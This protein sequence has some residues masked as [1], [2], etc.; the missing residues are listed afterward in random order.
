MKRVLQLL[1]IS[2]MILSVLLGNYRQK[3]EANKISLEKIS[4]VNTSVNKTSELNYIIEEDFD[5]GA[6][7]GTLPTDWSFE[8]TN[9]NCKD[10][11]WQVYWSVDYL[12]GFLLYYPY[13]NGGWQS[14]V[15]EGKTITCPI[16]FTGVETAAISFY[17]ELNYYSGSGIT[18][19]VKYRIGDSEWNS[20]WTETTTQTINNIQL[21]KVPEAC[22]NQ[23][24]VQ[25]ALVFKG[26]IA[27]IN[28]WIID[29]FQVFIP[30]TDEVF[31][32]DNNLNV[33]VQLNENF[34]PEIEI[35]SFGSS[36]NNFNMYC[37]IFHG[38][39]EIYNHSAIIE[40]LDF[41]SY[42][43]VIFPEFVVSESNNAYKFIFHSEYEIDAGSHDSNTG[44]KQAVVWE[45]FTNTGCGPCASL[46]PGLST[47]IKSMNQN[48][49]LPIYV[50]VSWPS[51]ADP[52]YTVLRDVCDARTQYY[53]ITGVPHGVVDGE[54]HPNIFSNIISNTTNAVS[55]SSN[56]GT[57]AL[58]TATTS[59]NN[60]GFSTVINVNMIGDV[61]NP[62]D[63]VLHV[64]AVENDLKFNAPNGERTF[65]WVLR[66]Y[67]PDVSG[68]TI[69]LIKGESDFYTI[70]GDFGGSW[71]R[72]EIDLYAFIQNNNTKR[73][74][75]G[76]RLVNSTS[77][78]NTDIN[79]IEKFSLE[80][81]Y[82][83]PFNPTT[84]ISYSIPKQDIV[85]INIYDIKGN[86]IR[87]L[88]NSTK[89]SGKYSVTWDAKSD[90][91]KLVPAGLYFYQLKSS[92]NIQTKKMLL[93]K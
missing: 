52:Y 21:I 84:Q 41:L 29:D 58:M 68:T 23:N 43:T 53:E 73:I 62:G 60:D 54:I 65:D 51:D 78:E 18:I 71:N 87:T 34:V 33:Q 42:Q 64:V 59:V 86:I 93:V 85:E 44:E 9:A 38:E 79:V 12:N 50:H 25:F 92:D 55:T 67:Y 76:M 75:Q 5:A 45:E 47:T 15:D 6:P 77:I 31:I 1:L 63:V 8:N 16:D 46:N 27:E 36:T 61:R 22:L 14:G 2:M 49:I 37:K 32:T 40:T 91:G 69:N 19:S 81:N 28:Y 11:I 13:F 80:Q 30:P 74:I 57:P 17:Q 26:Q 66:N 7:T 56:V 83:N 70:E 35:R 4:T 39:T 20:I 48:E 90:F 3:I 89:T 88:V 72:D 82:P 10:N 24:N